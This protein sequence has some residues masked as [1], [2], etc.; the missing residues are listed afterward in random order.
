MRD[1]RITHG[2]LIFGF[3]LEYRIHA[4]DSAYLLRGFSDFKYADHCLHLI[5]G[6]LEVSFA[7]SCHKK[8]QE[9]RLIFP[10]GLLGQGEQSLEFFRINVLQ[11]RILGASQDAS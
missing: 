5:F 10:A 8:R 2:G 9:F 3:L 4:V 6:K 7:G 11:R 1:M